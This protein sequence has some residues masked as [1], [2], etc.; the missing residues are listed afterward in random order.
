[1]GP[2]GLIPDVSL[3]KSDVDPIQYS[4]RVYSPTLDMF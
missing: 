3:I 2:L 4:S 1:M